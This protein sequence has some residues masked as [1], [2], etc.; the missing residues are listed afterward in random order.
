MDVEHN[1]ASLPVRLELPLAEPNESSLSHRQRLLLD[2]V[3]RVQQLANVEIGNDSSGFGDVSLDLT[4]PWKLVQPTGCS[5]TGLP[6]NEF[7]HVRLNGVS[8]STDF[9]VGGHCV[10]PPEVLGDC[11]RTGWGMP[12]PLAG[13]YHPV[14]RCTM[15]ETLLLFRAPRNDREV[16][17]LWHFVVKKSH[18]WLLSSEEDATC[19]CVDSSNIPMVDMD[20]VGIHLT[21]Q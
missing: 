17:V 4:G 14:L 3:S 16:N 20:I 7:G 18:Q 8:N 15:P 13:R 2:L 19:G 5:L 9:D 21:S 11:I 10:V 6:N 12:H 1:L